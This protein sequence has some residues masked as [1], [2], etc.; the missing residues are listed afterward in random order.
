MSGRAE[1][2]GQPASIGQD[3]GV[4]NY[5]LFTRYTAL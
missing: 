2:T 1:N 5:G 4:T 3:A